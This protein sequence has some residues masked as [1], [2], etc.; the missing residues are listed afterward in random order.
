MSS[1]A[2]VLGWLEKRGTKK[3]IAELDR[4]GITAHEPFGVP[5]GELRKYAKR[6]GK[7]HD[8]ALEL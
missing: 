1:V 6:L 4:Y 3:Q 5:V 2:E 8:L 7:D